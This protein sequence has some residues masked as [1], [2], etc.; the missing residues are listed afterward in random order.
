MSSK[1]VLKKLIILS[2]K[3]ST[4]YLKSLGYI[5]ENYSQG[6]KFENHKYQARI[7]VWETK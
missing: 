6:L 1:M 7:V 3:I 4:G 2:G 5:S